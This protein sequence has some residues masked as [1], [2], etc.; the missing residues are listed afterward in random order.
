[1]SIELDRL[2]EAVAKLTTSERADLAYTLLPSLDAEDGDGD[3]IE[4][5]WLAKVE[6][7]A[8]RVDR[9]EVTPVPGDEAFARLH[10]KFG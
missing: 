1:V 5:A 9:G 4:R 10:R 7:H 6:R 2:K 8:A 3:A